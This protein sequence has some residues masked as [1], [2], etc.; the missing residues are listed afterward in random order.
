MGNRLITK[1]EAEV[2][3]NALIEKGQLTFPVGTFAFGAL[4][5]TIFR[6]QRNGGK[7]TPRFRTKIFALLSDAYASILA[8]ILWVGPDNVDAWGAMFEGT[9][10]PC[11]HVKLKP[12]KSLKC[13]PS[14]PDAAALRR[15]I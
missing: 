11:F 15:L 8:F 13:D 4:S 7:F 2:L 1:K 6:I 10:K 12:N 9:A 3:K 5:G 14:G